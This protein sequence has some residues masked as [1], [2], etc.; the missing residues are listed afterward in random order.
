MSEAQNI[1]SLIGTWL[2]VFLAF[3]QV[4]LA[5]SMEKKKKSEQKIGGLSSEICALRRDQDRHYRVL[6]QQSQSMDDIAETLKKI[7][8]NTAGSNQNGGGSHSA[9]NSTT[10]D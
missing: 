8:R 4:V 9:T 1:A 5:Y 3:L 6:K 2:G 7:E 10:G